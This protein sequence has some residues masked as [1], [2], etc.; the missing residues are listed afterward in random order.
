[1]SLMKKTLV[2]AGALV[3]LVL[4]IA[5]FQPNEFRVERGTAIQ[6]PVQVT[7]DQVIDFHKWE[8]WSP[9]AKLDPSMKTVYEG[10]TSGVGA[11]MSWEGDG[12]VGAGK[13]TLVE[14]TPNQLI[15]IKVEFLKPFAA[16]N[17]VEFMFRSQSENQTAVVWTMN[18][19]NNFMAKLM[20]MVTSMD[21]MVG[22]DFDRGLVAL[23]STSES[24]ALTGTAT[25]PTGS[26]VRAVAGA[27]V[28]PAPSSKK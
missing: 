9:L 25:L 21:R 22:G 5:T 4:G 26:G 24:L 16:T 3:A 20:S 13:M 18:G 6:A 17:T 27:V 12:K 11:S 15:K 28:P 14:S 10:P 23:K 19:K 8:A 2:G 7:F 1:M